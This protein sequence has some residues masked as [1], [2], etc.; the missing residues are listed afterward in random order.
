MPADEAIR[1][2][3]LARYEI[4][5]S[6]AEEPFERI[7]RLAARLLRAPLVGLNFLDVDRLWSKSVQGGM[8]AQMPRTDAFC[9]WTIL[10][11]A[12]TVIG[13]L[14]ADQRFE[15][16]PAVAHEPHLR[17][18][19][20][21]PL[22][23]PSGHR[24]GTLCVMDHQ[25]RTFST[26]EIQA[27]QD[28]AATAMNELEL[29]MQLRQTSR[30]LEAQRERALDLQRSLAHA[31][32]LE[33]VGRLMELPI[34][35]ED[36]AL[37]AAAL[38]GQAIGAE[39]SGLVVYRGATTLTRR[40][41]TV[42]AIDPLLQNIDIHLNSAA[43]SVTETL[44]QLSEPYYLD[45]Y[46]DHPNALS[47]IVEHGLQSAAWIPLG[48]WGD[49]VF[50]LLALRVG[51]ALPIPWR[52]SDRSLL[53]AAARSV[54]AALNR[55]SAQA[56]AEHDAHTDSLTGVFNR[57]AFDET[58][59][60][61]DLHRDTLITM[62]DLDGFKALNDQEGHAQGDRVLRVFAGALSATLDGGSVYRLGGDEFALMVPGHWAEIEVDE[63]VDV[64]VLAAQQL[65]VHR[66][67]ASLG[68][69][70]TSEA[71]SIDEI[72]CLADTRMYE[73]KRQRKARRALATEPV[74]LS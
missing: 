3:D 43:K 59:Q 70:R 2:M 34:E 31:H 54:R 74:A 72:V 47:H 56:Q 69:A 35:P 20:G 46:R 27:L 65:G 61:L 17:A 5:D 28:L 64:A 62:I 49:Q 42:P 67:G 11:E 10:D 13:D 55:R 33:A 36:V 41:Y 22:T 48:R 52:D 15:H 57:R 39:W 24:I 23:T 12:P 68:M 73:K 58:C 51:E 8:P 71:S 53:D 44:A 38:I 29:R 63:C 60:G 26:D 30:Q 45:R 40:A 32:T 4:L 1:L 37:Q 6:G 7:T 14:P 50:H 18:Y 19:A 21:A 25:T 16:H 9:A 66:I